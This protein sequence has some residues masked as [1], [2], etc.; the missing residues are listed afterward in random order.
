[1]SS[2]SLEE[3]A[4]ELSSFA[5]PEKPQGRTREEERLITGF[6]E[7]LD[8]TKQHQRA[9]SSS[10]DADILERI[11]AT[12][13]EAL[14][15]N[16]KALELLEPMDASGLLTSAPA[17]PKAEDLSPEDLL[18]ALTE[19]RDLPQ[20]DITQLRHVPPAASRAAPDEVAQRKP[21]IDFHLYKRM[22]QQVANEVNNK[23]RLTR[24]YESTNSITQGALFIV[25]GQIAYV[26]KVGEE[27]E[28]SRGSKDA[29]LRVIYDNG[30]ESNILKWTLHR[31]LTEDDNGRIILD[32]ENQSLFQDHAP[33][34]GDSSGT[35]YVLKTKSSDPKLSE[36]RDVLHKVG[37]T[38]GDPKKR[39]A[40]APKEPTFLMADVE[41]VAEY[42]LYG[43]NRHKLENLLHRILA[44]GR[45][46]VQLTGPFG[47][48]QAPREW[49]IVPLTVIDE[50]VERIRDGSI[51]HYRYDPQ[52][53]ALTR[54]ETT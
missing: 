9:P 16:S 30:T 20:Q 3:L 19:G 18:A 28:H 33:A 50:I 10:A 27:F 17:T 15:R 39:F 53:A 1:M 51:T 26:D 44:P 42:K 2:P 7:I 45:L 38:G 14:R 25:N 48:K 34:E 43:I 22:F 32:P 12:R 54:I 8:F 41:L 24:R 4:Q 37:V 11:Y 40:N 29:R 52:A 5:P 46:D 31:T 47:H 6:Q 13:L 21:A 49:F 35:I 23:N 36:L